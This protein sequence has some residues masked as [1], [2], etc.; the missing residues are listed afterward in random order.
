MAPSASACH[1]IHIVHIAHSIE[2]VIHAHF[3]DP[4]AHV[5]DAHAAH[6]PQ[7]L[8]HGQ[9]VLPLLVLLRHLLGPVHQR[10]V[11]LRT[12]LP[13]GSDRLDQRGHRLVRRAIPLAQTLR[14]LLSG[15]F[16][17][18]VVPERGRIIS[19]A[20][21]IPTRLAV[22][23]RGLIL[24]V[25]VPPHDGHPILPHLHLGQEPPRRV[26]GP[27]FLD[28]VP[29]HGGLVALAGG[30][31]AQLVRGDEFAEFDVA[32]VGVG[33][34]AAAAEDVVGAGAGDVGEGV[35]GIGCRGHGDH[36]CVV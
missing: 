10:H 17:A 33:A 3:I 35:G 22:V 26:H 18:H 19:I 6:P 23:L 32:G 9:L 7:S 36:V 16:I 12:R 11:I 15:F 21:V 20:T 28:H 30:Q 4:H 34:A 13:I 25:L 1:G 29:R 14:R 2:I 5:V 31:V 27:P 24:L 8:H